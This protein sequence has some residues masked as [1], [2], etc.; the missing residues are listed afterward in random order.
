M[1]NAVSIIFHSR[2]SQYFKFAEKYIFSGIWWTSQIVLFYI[3]TVWRD[4][5]CLLQVEKQRLLHLW[6]TWYEFLRYF[7]NLK[8]NMLA[9]FN[10]WHYRALPLGSWPRFEKIAFK[11][12]NLL[13]RIKVTLVNFCR[14]RANKT[15]GDHIHWYQSVPVS[16]ARNSEQRYNKNNWLWSD[17]R[18]FESKFQKNLEFLVSIVLPNYLYTCKKWVNSNSLKSWLI[19]KWLD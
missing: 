7:G 6:L 8:R 11:T 3:L 10:S 15:F 18:D 17:Y 13:C 16:K 14:S 5:I 12:F 1:T 9:H 4:Y 19:E 2:K